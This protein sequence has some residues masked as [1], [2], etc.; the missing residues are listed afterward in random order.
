M[1]LV[2]AGQ[3]AGSQESLCTNLNHLE[4]PEALLPVEMGLGLLHL[5]PRPAG[6]WEAGKGQ[7]LLHHTLF[8]D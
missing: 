8:Q 5:F 3:E 7:A 2:S 4:L 1:A 6:L